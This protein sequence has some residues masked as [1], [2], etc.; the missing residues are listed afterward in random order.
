MEPSKI[1]ACEGGKLSKSLFKKA[2]IGM[3]QD[4]STQDATCSSVKV[5]GAA[6]LES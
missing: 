4:S 2:T 6:D 3:F 5:T 1:Y